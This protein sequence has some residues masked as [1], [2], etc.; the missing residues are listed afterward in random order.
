MKRLSLLSTTVL[1]SMSALANT[2]PSLSTVNDSNHK[3]LKVKAEFEQK[4]FEPTETLKAKVEQMFSRQSQSI[5]YFTAPYGM[6]AL[7]VVSNDFKKQVYYTNPD[8][9]FIFS[10]KMYDTKANEIHNNTITSLLKVEL[11]EVL[12]SGIQDAP[13]FDYGDGEQV[14]YAVVDANCGYCK[15]FHQAVTAQIESG[16]LQNVTVKYIPMGLLSEDSSTKAKAILSLPESERFD[17]W[18]AAV[19]RRPISLNTSTEGIKQFESVQA[20]YESQNVFRG[21]PFVLTNIAGEWKMSSGMP[22]QDFYDQLALSN[23][24]PDSSAGN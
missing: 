3:T 18:H 13:S 2:T 9:D 6:V 1:L 5:R 4:E 24:A 7:G 16:K 15:R 19:N 22:G 12:T 23:N 11:P 20:F 14:I 17:A 10:G 21:V 8:L